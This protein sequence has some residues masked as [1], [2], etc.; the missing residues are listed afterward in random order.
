MIAA[1]GLYFYIERAQAV[2]LLKDGYLAAGEGD[3]LT[4]APDYERPRH[5]SPKRQRKMPLR[6]L[7]KSRAGRTPY[8]TAQE[9]YAGERF[10]ADYARARQGGIT[11][12]RYDASGVFTAKSSDG[13]EAAMAARIDAHARL[14][15][16]RTYAGPQLSKILNALLGQDM[17]LLEFEA[18]A[19][20][21]KCSAKPVFKKA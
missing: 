1:V 21:A 8:L 2:R 18:Q 9:V 3:V 16:A 12:Q 5:V 19:G 11:Q 17:G 6:G 10:A 13:Q 14:R 4:F 20:W 15:N 7:R